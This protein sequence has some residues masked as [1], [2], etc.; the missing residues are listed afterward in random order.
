MKRCV[1][2]SVLLFFS[3]F[4]VSAAAVGA[5][6]DICATFTVTLVEKNNSQ[7][8]QEKQGTAKSCKG[9]AKWGSFGE[10]AKT[11]QYQIITYFK[12][13]DFQAVNPKAMGRMSKSFKSSMQD[14]V[15]FYS[16]AFPKA[17]WQNQ[18][19]AGTKR[20]T[21]SNI[22]VAGKLHQ[23]PTE[24]EIAEKNGKRRSIMTT[25]LSRKVLGMPDIDTDTFKIND[26]FVMRSVVPFAS[27][28]GSL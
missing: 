17:K 7:Q 2:P 21:M 1:A 4:G 25:K 11:R 27:V 22:L 23:V 6:E 8:W 12:I 14:T 28:Q 13:P 10:S 9:T 24:V 15:F 5:P 26:S 19:K 20:Q 18:W 3:V 16:E